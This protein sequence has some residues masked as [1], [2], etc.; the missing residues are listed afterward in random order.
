MI[1]EKR[2]SRDVIDFLEKAKIDIVKISFLS[3][4]SE[5]HLPKLNCLKNGDRFVNEIPIA[6]I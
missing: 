6:L 3:D 1:G 4:C 5:F 2:F